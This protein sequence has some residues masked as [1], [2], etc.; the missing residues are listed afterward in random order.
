MLLDDAGETLAQR[1]RPCAVLPGP[2]YP[3]LDLDGI[4]AWAVEALGELARLAPDR[5]HRAGGAWCRR[6]C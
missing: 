6:P 5:L 1:S 2:P 4:W 3:Q